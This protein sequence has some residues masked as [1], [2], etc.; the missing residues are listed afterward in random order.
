MGRLLSLLVGRCS[1][2]MIAHP[3]H[4][5]IL[6]A[7]WLLAVDGCGINLT[8]KTDATASCLKNGG[9]GTSLVGYSAAMDALKG[10]R[11]LQAGQPAPPQDLI[12]NPAA[13]AMALLMESSRACAVKCLRQA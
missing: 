7:R 10:G 1:L 12:A 3:A 4:C 9:D 2:G 11:R 6:A 5:L 8:G 13:G